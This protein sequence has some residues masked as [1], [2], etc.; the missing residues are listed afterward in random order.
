[1]AQRRYAITSPSDY[2]ATG[3]SE[4]LLNA[5]EHSQLLMDN[6]VIVHRRTMD[7]PAPFVPKL[8][9]K[10]GVSILDLLHGD[11]ETESGHGIEK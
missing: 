5:P 7:K 4:R 1:M 6:G 9:V 8:A 11:D 3:P 10:A 2:G